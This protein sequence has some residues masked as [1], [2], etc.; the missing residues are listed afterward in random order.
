MV[1]RLE[2]IGYG[3]ESLQNVVSSNPGLVIQTTEKLFLCESGKDKAA[4]GDG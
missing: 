4:K 3:A 2:L 1:V